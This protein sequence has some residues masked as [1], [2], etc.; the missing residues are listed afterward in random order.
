LRKKNFQGISGENP[1]GAYL[2]SRNGKLRLKR[3]L[4]AP[5]DTFLRQAVLFFAREAVERWGP[6]VALEHAV[7]TST[8][9][10]ID[11]GILDVTVTVHLI[12]NLS[13]SHVIT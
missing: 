13:Q 10:D 11:Q 6:R 4:W 7:M 1:H 9:E 2:K 5:Y 3:L 8:P 12:N